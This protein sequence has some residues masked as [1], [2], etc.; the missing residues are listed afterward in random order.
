MINMSSCHGFFDKKRIKCEWNLNTLKVL[1]SFFKFMLNLASGCLGTAKSRKQCP[2]LCET[3]AR[4]RNPPDD[5]LSEE[6]LI[7]N[8][9]EN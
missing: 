6:N 9:S 1:L 3:L 8:V 7:Y 2:G 5:I 4:L